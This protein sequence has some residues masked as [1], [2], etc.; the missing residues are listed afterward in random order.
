MNEKNTSLL[1][2]YF[3]LMILTG[4]DYDSRGSNYDRV[5]I[6]LK[7]YELIR[8]NYGDADLQLALNKKIILA[9]YNL[10]TNVSSIKISLI[11]KKSVLYFAGRG[12]FNNTVQITIQESYRILNK[13]NI[14][15]LYFEVFN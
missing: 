14:L 9:T 1:L 5:N 3:G 6:I 8:I 11:S 13:T 12:L 10:L 15:R 4:H 7:K 2:K